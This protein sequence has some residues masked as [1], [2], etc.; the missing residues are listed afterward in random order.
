MTDYPEIRRISY[1][2]P[3]DS[4]GTAVFVPVCEKC[5]RFVKAHITILV[6]EHSGL[7]DEPNADCSRC[8]PTKMLFEGFF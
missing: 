8:G 1:P 3:E 4:I 5:G 6:S 2:D 7:E